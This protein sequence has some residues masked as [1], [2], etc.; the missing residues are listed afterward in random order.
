MNIH[1]LGAFFT[2]KRIAIIGVSSN[3]NSVS[4]KTLSNLVSGGFRG[5]VY[6]VNPNFEAVMGM[7]CFKD[8][9]SLPNVPDLAIICTE[10]SMVPEAVRECGEAGVA[11]IIIMSAG[12]KEIGEKG[13]QLE[14]EVQRELVKFEKMR[15]LGPNCLGVISPGNKLNASFAADMPKEGNIAF[16]SQSGALCTSVLDFALEAKIG[17][18]HF[19]SVGNCLD[20]DFADLID[21]LG[22]D[23]KTH[24]IILY[25]E[26]ISRVRQFM[27]AARSFA[28]QKPIIV[29]KAGRF[30]ESAKAAASHT[31]AMASEDAIYDAA[32]K[33]AGL[34][35]VFDIGDIFDCAALIGMNKI[36][37]G[38]RLGI[39]TNAG[40]PG[41]MAT[42]SLLQLN[43]CLARLND[44]TM[45]ALNENLP[46][47][48]SHRNPIDVLGDARSKRIGKVT[49][50]VLDDP[51]VDALLVIVTPQAM[52]NPTIIAEEIIKV[53]ETV[54]KPILAAWIG[55]SSMSEGIKK[56]NTA[57]IPAY[58]TPEQAI[59]SFMT[60]VQYSS[61]LQT[62]YETP[63]DIPFEFQYNRDQL[64]VDFLSSI[65]PS[66]PILSEETSK[67]LL[68]SY[69]IPVTMP[70]TAKSADQAVAL[71][72][73]IGFPVVLKILSPDINHKSDVGGVMLNLEN[74]N[75]VRVGYERMVLS[76][77]L[78]YP[79]ARIVGASVQ[80]M[81]S[82]KDSVEMILGIKRDQVFGTVIMAG[83][84]G[85]YAE[86][87]N[88]RSL[89]F[90]PLNERLA[91]LMLEKLKIYPL[92]KG[93]RG[94]SPKNIDKSIEIIIRLSYLA[95]D[96][97]EIVE[98]DINPLLVTTDNVIALDA[99]IAIDLNQKRSEL[100][101][102]QHLALHPYPEK[103]VQVKMLGDCEIHLRPIKPEDEPLWLDF[104]GSC[105]KESIYSRFRYF[106]HWDS[107]EVA[108]KYCYI[109]YDREIAIVA[110]IKDG[111][112]SRI[113]GIGRL[114]A[115]P[116]HETVEYAVLVTDSWQNK[117]LGSLLTD[118]CMDIATK[119][120]L[121]RIVA[122]TTTDNSRMISM[123]EKRGFKI[124]YDSD[125]TV[126][127]DKEL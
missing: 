40:G 44:N 96:Y 67:R 105:S 13:K 102:Y 31:G 116:E 83:M 32:F 100:N 5:V 23:E 64:R 79:D 71:A 80:P 65:N 60:L 92:L 11:G 10:S 72:K 36:P 111:N 66:E 121:K 89:G 49:K 114:I 26:S 29:Y 107:H 90:P 50:I 75:M 112:E 41:V 81:V 88:D 115:D 48:W 9:K 45:Q 28:R 103:Y 21:F 18:S 6:P 62:L 99:R 123:F 86:L 109:D 87:F 19:I 122:Q 8:L 54:S 70:R 76:V 38:P 47:F 108:T 98:L 22:E 46:E 91:R 127:V 58:Q 2:P 3:P 94:S 68:E 125:S 35:R 97:P 51:G 77:K 17:F 73:E 33:R 59:R 20:V 78:C 82:F 93:Y 14:E 55:G 118:F 74:E 42:D 53:G 61:N 57:G 95:A 1:K 101:P 52:T 15:I 110:T 24:S 117:E 30:A 113:V 124:L 56:L 63:R 12:F 43:G 106:F 4:G 126:E 119:W 34:I 120:N 39:I 104:L 84:G 7:L 16:I 69:G 37:K 25:I 85:I 27:T